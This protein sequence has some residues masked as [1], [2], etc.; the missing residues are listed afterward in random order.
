MAD[1][2]PQLAWAARADGHI[3][4]YNQ[5]WFAY[6]GTTPEQMEGWG[7]QSVHDPVSLPKVIQAWQ[8]AIASGTSFEMEFP[9]RSADGRFRTFLTRVAPSKDSEGRVVNWFGTNTDITDRKQAEATIIRLR[10]A[11]AEKGLAIEQNRM[12]SQFLANMS[13]ELRTPLNAIIGFTGTLLMKLPGPLSPDQESQLHTVQASA[14]HLL[15]LINDLL[16]VA[17]IE[18]GKIQ[19]NLE[20]VVCQHIIDELIKTMRPS[21]EAKGL[22][23]DAI[24]PADNTVVRA[25]RRMMSQL[26]LNLT[27][28]AIKFTNRGSV[29]IGLEQKRNG[30]KTLT[31]ISVSDTGTGI[32]QEDQAR[33][34]K[35]FSQVDSSNTRPYGG[36]GLG[37]HLSQ[38]LAGMIGGQ[39]IFRSEYG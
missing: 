19:V 18:S 25:D 20:P 39:I 22:R 17:R 27:S 8:A 32:R 26:L 15:S 34:F 1:S 6:T 7:W 13:H 16:D 35:A 36:T 33:L 29:T 38:K 12:K 23:L 28:N 9:L 37:L 5:R 4:W 14:K 21:A 10:V 24:V 30:D 2:I 3:Y 11:E 31:Q